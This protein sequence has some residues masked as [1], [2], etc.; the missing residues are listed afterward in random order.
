MYTTTERCSGPWAPGIPAWSGGRPPAPG[1]AGSESE[2]RRP[3]VMAEFMTR[4]RTDDDPCSP[5]GITLHSNCPS[6]DRKLVFHQS[7]SLTRT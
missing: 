7:A 6:C 1:G 4:M 3:R 2:G 5:N